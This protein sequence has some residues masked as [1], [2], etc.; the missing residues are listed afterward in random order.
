VFRV[1]N[2]ARGSAAATTHIT[3]NTDESCLSRTINFSSFE[4]LFVK[5]RHRPGPVSC[6]YGAHRAS[7]RLERDLDAEQENATNPDISCRLGRLSVGV[8]RVEVI[9]L[10]PLAL[11]FA[12]FASAPLAAYF[13]YALGE[14][15]RS[16]A[17]I[18]YD[19]QSLNRKSPRV[20]R[21]M[22]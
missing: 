10:K 6:G 7:T 12:V 14:H 18:P 3:P 9:M 19:W 15:T 5:L 1:I 8:V 21:R 16:A 2:R 17:D 13:A 22:L 4:R 11:A 20:R